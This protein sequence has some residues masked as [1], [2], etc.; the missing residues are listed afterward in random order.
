[1]VPIY[2]RVIF[3]VL[4]IINFTFILVPAWSLAQGISKDGL[5]NLAAAANS[6]K[7]NHPIQKIYL[8]F[9]KPYYAIGDT[10]WFKAY[11]FNAAYLTP[12]DK[13]GICY[14]ELADKDNKVVNRMMLPVAKGLTWGSMALDEKNIPEGNYTI[15]AYSSLMCNFGDDYIFKKSFY[16]FNALNDVLV[17]TKNSLSKDN[18]MEKA[19]INLQFNHLNKEAVILKQMHLSVTDGQSILYQ[20]EVAT[21][22]DGSLDLDL[23]FR[24]PPRHLALQFTGAGGSANGQK[25]DIPVTY[26]LSENTDLQFMPEGGNLV[27]GLPAHIGFKAVSPD[28]KSVEIE[29]NV[30]D[31]K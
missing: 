11:L 17:N 22:N 20:K 23:L 25:L 10:I 8:Q 24:S 21:K 12:A 30:F 26:N 18:G 29:G 7:N 15:R 13:T 2:K 14:V 6:F 19:H 3:T 9:D 16:F 31:S 27:D 28:G 1:M 4:F 5:L